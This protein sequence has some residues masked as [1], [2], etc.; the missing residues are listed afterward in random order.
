MAAGI[1]LETSRSVATLSYPPPGVR[2]MSNVAT[3]NPP[4]VHADG[5]APQAQSSGP[6]TIHQ[7]IHKVA[8]LGAGTMGARI[9]AHIA[10]AGL[11]CVLLDMVPPDAAPSSDRA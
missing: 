10:N 8:V 4:Q 5:A 3:V 11:P 1:M 6:K 7:R 2:L 9:A